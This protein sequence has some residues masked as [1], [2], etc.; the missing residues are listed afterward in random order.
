MLV[1][2]PSKSRVPPSFLF[3]RQLLSH[4]AG[5]VNRFLCG[6][7]CLTFISATPPIFNISS[8]C[9][10][11]ASIW[12]TAMGKRPGKQLLHTKGP[13]IVFESCLHMGLLISSNACPTFPRLCFNIE[14]QQCSANLGTSSPGASPRCSAPTYASLHR[15]QVFGYRPCTH[16]H[17]TA[18]PHYEL[19]NSL[20]HPYRSHVHVWPQSALPRSPSHT[21]RCTTSYPGSC[22]LPSPIYDPPGCTFRCDPC[23]FWPILPEHGMKTPLLLLPHNRSF[24]VNGTGNRL[25]NYRIAER[26]VSVC[27][28]NFI[29]I[30]A[31][32]ERFCSAAK[33]SSGQA[34]ALAA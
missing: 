11:I 2:P 12:L 30:A 1:Y 31:P 22:R 15:N 24:L 33:C 7:P 34:Q 9:Q 14:I 5:C 17:L 26:L 10:H 27:V 29:A 32:R 6:E 20:P 13:A 8:C 25:R 28:V 21:D 16:L 3:E 4:I 19:I 18:C 23:L